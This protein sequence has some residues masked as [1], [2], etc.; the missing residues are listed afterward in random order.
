MRIGIFTDT[1]P[2]QINGV[3]NS[4]NILFEELKKNNHDVYVI[5][6]YKG[7]GEHKWNKDHT[8]LRLAGM[9]LKFLYGYVM[10]S[11]IHLLAL[12]EIGKLNL[13]VIHAQTEFGVGIFARICARKFDIPLVSTYHTTY[14]DYTHYVNFTHLKA[15]DN[16]SKKGVASLSRM[17]GDSSE[18]VIAPSHKTKEMLEHYNVHRQINVIPTGLQLEKFSPVLKDEKKRSEIRREAGFGDQDIMIIYVGRLAKEKSMD[19]VVDGFEKASALGI[20]VKLMIVG[21]GPD[22]EP[23]KTMVKKKNLGDMIVLTGPKPSSEVP[24]YYRSAD[25]FISA[26]LSETQGMTFI[27]AMAAGIP[28][29]A[30][31]DEV[32][33]DLIDEGKTGWFFRDSDD[34]AVKLGNFVKMTEEERKAVSENCLVK[35]R[36]YSSAVFGERVMEVYE[37]VV[38]EY[39]RRSTVKSAEVKNTGILITLTQADGKTTE[40]TVSPEDYHEFNIRVGQKLTHETLDLLIGREAGRSAF[41]KCLRRLSY[42]DRTEKEMTDFLKENTDCSEEQII[43]VIDKL[44]SNNLINDE[45]YCRDMIERMQAGLKGRKRILTALVMKG[46]P[47]SMA[48]RILDEMTGDE[49]ESAVRY[50]EKLMH[51]DREDSVRKRKSRIYARLVQQGYS[52]ETASE[53]LAFLDFTDAENAEAEHLDK[54]FKKAKKRYAAKY[55]GEELKRHIYQYCLGQGFRSSDIKKKLEELTDE[56]KD[57]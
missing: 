1:F 13:D 52:G 25:A 6:T 55:K 23:L 15:V 33:E 50:A 42:K 30:R 14:E 34:L 35:V 5:T 51:S 47:E 26:S 44:K 31:R 54:C 53:A 10:T 16:L 21:G 45:K 4:T 28:L 19:V 57:Q 48:E 37:R 41:E 12:D 24:D 2:P 3:A 39:G 11:P 36:P 43:N 40:I 27:E 7:I 8:I 22:L 38:E 17:Y 9:E 49:K 29:F 18:E 56:E 46:I 32:L 20:N